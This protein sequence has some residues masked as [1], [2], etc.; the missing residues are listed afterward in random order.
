L[1][2]AATIN[3]KAC[4]KNA[5]LSSSS[6]SEDF[7]ATHWSEINYTDDTAANAAQKTADEAKT[8]LIDKLDLTNKNNKATG[9]RYLWADNGLSIWDKNLDS[10][11]PEAPNEKNTIFTIYQ[12]TDKKYELKMK[13]SG[14]FTGTITAQDGY[15]GNLLIKGGAITTTNASSGNN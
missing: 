9:F 2:E 13:G 12:N 7:D 6:D 1:P 3:G 10:T 4:K 8:G 11:S 14:E 5:I 15:I